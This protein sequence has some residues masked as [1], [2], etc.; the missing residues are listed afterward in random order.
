M[1]QHI[2]VTGPGETLK[3]L[4]LSPSV[5]PHSPVQVFCKNTVL[6]E[7]PRAQPQ[8]LR[9]TPQTHVQE[10]SLG[11]RGLRLANIA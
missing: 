3:E 6:Q 10:P 8:S 11:V 2:W 7:L 5:K 4:T 1:R 9:T